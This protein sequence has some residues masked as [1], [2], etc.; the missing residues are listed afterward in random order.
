MFVV[1]VLVAGDYQLRTWDLDTA[2]ETSSVELE[3]AGLLHVFVLGLRDT[4]AL[5]MNSYYK[6]RIQCW[7]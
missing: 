7:Y 1:S 4:H 2:N 5:L 3:S 6:V